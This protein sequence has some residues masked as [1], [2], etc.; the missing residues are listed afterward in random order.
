MP[1]ESLSRDPDNAR[2]HGPRSLDTIAALIKR[3]GQRIPVVVQEKGRIIRA[4]NGTHEAMER[5][6]YATIAAVI[7]DDDELT[8][9]GFA[10]TDNRT[11]ELATWNYRT[12]ASLIRGL[13]AEGFDLQELGWAAHEAGPI[14][15]AQWIERGT[16]G[17]AHTD[18]GNHVT[19]HTDPA[20][21]AIITQA[22]NRRREE[23]DEMDLAPGAALLGIAQ[24]WAEAHP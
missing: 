13:T 10:I 1:I 5:L 15:D 14:L 21:A 17:S 12:L 7:I 8:A 23:L 11:A 20:Q 3:F 18:G 19:V 22:I 9:A 2:S 16:S 4:G 6:G 24:A